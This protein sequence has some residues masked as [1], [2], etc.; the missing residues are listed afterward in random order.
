MRVCM[1]GFTVYEADNRVRR[2]AETLAK[3]GDEVDFIGLGYGG[4]PVKDSIGGVRIYRIQDKLTDEPGQLSSLARLLA[5][6]FR[7]MLCLI[8]KELR[9]HYDLIHVHSIPD[10]EVFA[11]WFSKLR[12]SRVILDIHDLVPELYA[13]KFTTSRSVLKRLLIG[14]ERLSAGYADHVIVANHIWQETLLSRSLRKEKCTTILNFPDTA[15][16]HRR[17][18]TRADGKF[19]MLYPGSLNYHQGVDIAIRA[20]ALIKDQVPHAEFRIYGAGPQWNALERLVIELGLEGRVY[21]NKPLAITDI[22]AAMEEAD[23]GIVPKRRDSFGNEAFSTKI[24]EFMAMG[25]PVAV[26]DTRIDRYYFNESVVQFFQSNDETD[27]ANCI[28]RL[29]RDRDMRLGLASRAEAFVKGYIWE[30]RKNEYVQLVDGLMN[31]PTAE[32]SARA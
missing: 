27:L 5:F 12:G 4:F 26:S 32:T 15:I 29:I 2:Y 19:V 21:L 18:Q 16:F 11:T 31:S 23:L 30:V 22:A 14:V 13:S 9:H 25:I 17:G 10:F 24:L 1:L 3:R 7:S 6:F 8:M 28:L 20:F